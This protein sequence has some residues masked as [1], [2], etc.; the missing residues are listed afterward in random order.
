M[1]TWYKRKI[2][3]ILQGLLDIPGEKSLQVGVGLENTNP[4]HIEQFLLA[5]E[6]RVKRKEKS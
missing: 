6:L 3:K 4:A 1:K 5:Q 2:R